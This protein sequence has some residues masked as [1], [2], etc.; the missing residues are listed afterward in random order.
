MTKSDLIARLLTLKPYL[1]QFHAEKIVDTILEEISKTLAAG[2]RVE[3]R[4]FGAFFIKQRR[5]RTARN[6][7]TGGT[8]QVE[9][10]KLP[11]FKPGRTMHELLNGIAVRRRQRVSGGE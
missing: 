3:L 8:V 1:R 9:S 10:K 5:A 6:P 4:G 7:R 2:G 11:F